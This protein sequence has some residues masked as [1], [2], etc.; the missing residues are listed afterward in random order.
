MHDAG[1]S[2][3]DMA[4]NLDVSPSTVRRWLG[5]LGI[6]EVPSRRPSRAKAKPGRGKFDVDEFYRRHGAGES[7][8]VIAAAMGLSYEA[9]RRHRKMRGLLPNRSES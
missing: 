7:D 6:G 9:V 3:M 1:L 4:V 5:V 8:S 2:L